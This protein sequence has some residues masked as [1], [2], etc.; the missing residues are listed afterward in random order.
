TFSPAACNLTCTSTITVQTATSTPTGSYPITVTGTAGSLS[1]TTGF[2]LS[3]TASNS[4]DTVPPSVAIT[5]PLNGS[6]VSRKSTVTIT[7]TAS[8]N[9]AVAKVEFSVNGNLLCTDVSTPY[10]CSWKVPNQRQS[11]T[12]SAK[13]YDNAG[14][15]AV[16]TVQVTAK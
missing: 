5:S 15:T 9:S 14:N 12:I 6:T 8:D 10:A 4:V 7:A 2:T 13:A 3:V 16:S 1:R 11:Y